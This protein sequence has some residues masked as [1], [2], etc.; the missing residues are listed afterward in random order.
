MSKVQFTK[1]DRGYAHYETGV[2]IIKINPALTAY[3]VLI[4]GAPM[5]RLGS[6]AAAKKAATTAV[7]AALATR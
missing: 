2:T 3:A 7:L 4:P 1:V 6:F 5:Q